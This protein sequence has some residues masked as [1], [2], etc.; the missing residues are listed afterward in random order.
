[1]IVSGCGRLL[2]SGP[3]LFLLQF[4]LLF[5]IQCRSEFIVSDVAKVF[6]VQ[7]LDFLP[8]NF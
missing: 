6:L 1:M 7:Y 2:E 8:V 5:L 3:L 4:R